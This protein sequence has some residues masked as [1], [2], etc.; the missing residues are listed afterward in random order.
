MT[1]DRELTLVLSERRL[2]TDSAP[3]FYE[4]LMRNI[5]GATSLT[6]DM[7][8]VV[9][10]SSAGLRA[11]LSAQ[12][13]MVEGQGPLPGGG[14]RV[15]LRNVSEEVMSTLEVTGFSEIFNVEPAPGRGEVKA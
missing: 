6:V 11:L 3:R 12:H 7:S 2:D 9:Y 1:E 4:V 10:I 8:A 5:A 13:A 14:S 15:T